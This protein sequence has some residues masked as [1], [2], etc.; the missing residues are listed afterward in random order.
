MTQDMTLEQLIHCVIDFQRNAGHTELYINQLQMVY[1]RLLKLSEE[2]GE[3]HF[4]DELTAAF[5]ADDKNSYTGEYS[6]S[7]FLSHHRAI[8]FLQSYMKTG[9]VIV[10]RYSAYTESSIP[11][12]FSRALKIYDKSESE[13]GLSKSSLIK[14]RKPIFYLLE[15]MA[16]LGYET[17]SDIQSGD[18]LRAIQDILENHYSASSLCTA[19][20]GM[21]RFYR[22]FP[23][24]YPYRLEIPDRMIRERTIIDTYTE[25]E[26]EKIKAVLFSDDITR[27]DAA[28][29]LLCFETGLRAVDIKKMKPTDIDWKH[30][31]IHIIQSK[32]KEPLNLPLR[33]SYGNAMVD[34][35]L[36]ERPKC[37]SEVFFLS[38]RAPFIEL[39]TITHI[40]KN[41][42][43]LSGI[44]T[45]GRGCGPR[46]FRHNAASTMVKKGVPLPAISEELGHKNLDSTM[47]YIAN[48]KDI[49]ASLTLPLPP[50][51]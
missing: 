13:S 26:Q 27:R 14:N 10:N 22:M 32:T 28:I 51:G 21:R 9:E 39:K 44:D 17:L 37:E 41:I 3:S 30:N 42:I 34:Y 24:L 48:D 45:K 8:S 7:R 4:S 6:H 16:G 49:M 11:E 25:E 38:A 35:L 19:I 31:V 20:S 50:R 33:S 18:T 40:I 23:E 15:Y 46:M 47:V 5:L 29:G 36:S 12:D 43:L 2:M 1:N